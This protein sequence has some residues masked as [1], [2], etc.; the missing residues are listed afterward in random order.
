MFSLISQPTIYFAAMW[1]GLA[2]SNAIG[3]D[4]D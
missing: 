3:A 2:I 1:V 4:D